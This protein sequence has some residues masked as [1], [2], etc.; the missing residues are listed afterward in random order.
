MVKMTIGLVLT[1]LLTLAPIIASA[2]AES[3]G[4]LE[5]LS[6]CAVCHG[7][8][9]KG[10]GSFSVFLNVDVPDLTQY[11]KN[12]ND[13]FHITYI[14]DII[15]GQVEVAAHGDRDMAIWG[16]RYNAELATKLGDICPVDDTTVESQIRGR[17]LDLAFYLQSIQE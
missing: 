15:A 6:S 8:E 1:I 2:E 3:I 4:K 11:A 17:I 16:S 14:S 5:Y 9:G 12:N 10:D 7:T 13:I